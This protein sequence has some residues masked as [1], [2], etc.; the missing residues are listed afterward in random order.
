MKDQ[1]FP[2]YDWLITKEIASFLLFV[3]LICISLG[4]CCIFN[5]IILKADVIVFWKRIVD[6]ASLELI[7]E[8]NYNG[9]E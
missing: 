6:F 3:F 2:A 7:Y 8:S 5:R 1:G 9:M 4:S